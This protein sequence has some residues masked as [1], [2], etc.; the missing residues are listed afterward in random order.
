MMLMDR[1]TF[2]RLYLRILSRW[3][4]LFEKDVCE[5]RFESS[6]KI[7]WLYIQK[8]YGQPPTIYG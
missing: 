5:N 3:K 7:F 4:H 1:D 2:D 6:P 8:I